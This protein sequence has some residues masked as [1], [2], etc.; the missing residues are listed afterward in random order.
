MKNQGKE[1]D[2]A[3]LQKKIVILIDIVTMMRP[4]SDLECL[5]YQ[6]AN[7]TWPDK[8]QLFEVSLI[9]REPKEG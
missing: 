2:L 3:R 6:D 8:G 4:R 5:Q 1:L 9:S 7:F